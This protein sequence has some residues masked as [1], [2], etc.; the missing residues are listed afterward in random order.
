MDMVQ[1]VRKGFSSASVELTDA[2]NKNKNIT[3]DVGQVM[4][5]PTVTISSDVMRQYEA[6]NNSSN[7]KWFVSEVEDGGRKGIKFPYEYKTKNYV[8][9]LQWLIGLE[10]F[11]LVK[12][13]SRVFFTTD[14]PNGAH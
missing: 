13:P 11:L 10:I 4:F 3:I 9:A 6:R 5:K 12:D 2:V 14:H 7:K 8:N 1:K